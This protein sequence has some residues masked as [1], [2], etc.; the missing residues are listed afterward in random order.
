MG[1]KPL[2]KLVGKPAANHDGTRRQP[3]N[4]IAHFG[5]GLQHRMVFRYV[6]IG[7]RVFEFDHPAIFTPEVRQRV[8]VELLEARGEML[9]AARLQNVNDR[10]EIAMFLIHR[11]V[12]GQECVAPREKR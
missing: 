3:G 11:P 8:Y 1:W 2:C 5:N 7:F 10:D 12:A 9:V 4:Q 6:A